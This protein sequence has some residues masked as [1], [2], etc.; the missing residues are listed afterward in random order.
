MERRLGGERRSS[1]WPKYGP[2][3][4]EAPVPDTTIDAIVC[5]QTVT[6]AWLSSERPNKQLAEKSGTSVVELWKGRKRFE[7]GNPIERPVVSMNLD[8]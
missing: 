3:S 1:D 5:L 4:G 7:E 8:A 2:I 6:L